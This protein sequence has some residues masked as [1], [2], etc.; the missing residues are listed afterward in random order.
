[1]MFQQPAWHRDLRFLGGS[2]DSEQALIDRYEDEIRA[3]ARTYGIDNGA[4]MRAQHAKMLGGFGKARFRIANDL[5]EELQIGFLSP[6][7]EYPAEV[8]FSN[9][10]SALASSDA[11]PDLRGVAIRVLIEKDVAMDFLMTNA[12]RHHARDA[13]E[14]MAT[15]VAFAVNGPFRKLRGFFRLAFRIGFSDAIRVIRTL[16]AQMAIP[17]ESLASETYYSRAPLAID[18]IAVK[19][20]LAPKLEKSKQPSAISDLGAEL[21]RRLAEG[22]VVFTFQVQLYVNSSTTPIEDSTVEWDSPFITMGELVIP[23]GSEMDETLDRQA[24][25]PWNVPSDD[26]APIGSMNRARLRVYEASASL[27]ARP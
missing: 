18:S 21:L 26:F 10:S 7:S 8:R 15:T 17:V 25:N 16:K 13:E 23:K 19:Y 24:F 6:G 3:V 1:M 4:I 22:D 9:A 2:R 12:N 20:R 5:P 11:D 27:R 14:A